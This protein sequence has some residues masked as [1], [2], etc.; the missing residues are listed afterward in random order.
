MCFKC[1]NTGHYA[2]DCPEKKME[3]AKLTTHRYSSKVTTK[4]CYSCEE[5]GHYSRDCPIKRTRSSA[6][7]IEY[8]RQEIEDLLALGESKK[9]RKLG[10]NQHHS[11]PKRYISQ[12]LCFKCNNKGHYANE[13]PEKMAEEAAKANALDKGYENHSKME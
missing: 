8:D 2:N 4:C 6:F 3:E 1:K 7:K 11:E 12:V 9:K 13:C 5:E 10:S